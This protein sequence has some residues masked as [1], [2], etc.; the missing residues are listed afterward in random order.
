[1]IKRCCP[2]CVGEE[3]K[4]IFHRDFGGMESI[5]PFA[6]YDV[7]QCM[8]CGAFYADNIGETMPLMHYYEMMSK[9]ETEAF[10]VSQ[11]ALAEYAF[12]I[13][14]LRG[15]IAPEQSIIDI[16]CGNGAMLHMLQEQGF[17]HLTGLEPS[18]KNCRGITERW[19]IRAVAG[20]LGED[21]PPLVGETFDVVLME[22][23][24]E[25]LLDVQGNVRDALAYLKKDGALYLNVPDLAAFPDCHDLYQ[26]FSVE[27]VNFFSLPSMQNLMGAFGMTC[28]AYDRNGYGVFTLW[29]HASEG[30]PARTFDQAGTADMRTYLARA[31]QLAAQMKARLAPYC[32]REVYVWAAGTHTA[33]L[34]QLGLL[35]GIHV[36]AIIDSNANYQGKEIYGVP[37]IAP[38]ELAARDPL[39]I[40]I[41]SQLAQDAIY[42]Q[43]TER[44][45]LTNEVIRL[46]KKY[47]EEL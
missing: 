13:G 41:S 8:R 23:V 17:R 30:V 19:G 33:M 1:M 22:G 21:I 36:R 3:T 25:H 7:V 24:L 14:F 18:E 46:Y 38:Q 42:T 31:E 2:V 6:G 44:M 26:Q 35:D 4:K 39:P 20:A 28:V 34:Y 37:V 15:H 29:R 47:I 43:I 40:I 12:A 45:K 16:G 32:G 27:H 11:E 9:Y 10:S 5:V